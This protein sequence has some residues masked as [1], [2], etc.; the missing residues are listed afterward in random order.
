LV[1]AAISGLFSLEWAF[2]LAAASGV[3]LPTLGPYWLL[4]LGLLTAGLFAAVTVRWLS[5]PRQMWLGAVVASILH[6]STLGRYWR[7]AWAGSFGDAGLLESLATG[8]RDWTLGYPLLTLGA[9]L[10]YPL[11][12][13]LVA[14]LVS[15]RAAVVTP[16]VGD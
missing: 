15:S 6:L 8:F 11:V 9:L 12:V 13:W 14:R 5:A 16:T 2:Y 10:G 7:R 1:V 3:A 4:A